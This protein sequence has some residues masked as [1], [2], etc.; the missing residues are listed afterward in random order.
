MFVYR[1]ANAKYQAATLAGTGAEKVGGR[2]NKIGTRAVYCS[3]NISLALLEYYVHSDNIALLPKDLLVAKIQ[4]P[5]HFIVEE[6][7]KLP[8]RWKKYPYASATSEV[9]TD[10]VKKKDF[11]AIK[12][13]STIVER[14][15][16]IILNPLYKDFG[17]VEILE[18]IKLAIDG[19]LRFKLSS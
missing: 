3:E 4:I 8:H 10:L 19:R 9:F 11:F 6:L 7:N 18:F 1:I 16:N 12:V 17:K 13:P 5:D 14:E 2:W 15:S